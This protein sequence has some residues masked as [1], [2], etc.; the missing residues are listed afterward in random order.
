MVS[1]PVT[2][3]KVDGETVRDI[4][5]LDSKITVHSDHNHEIKML[6]SLQKKLWQT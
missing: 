1:S 5:F 4:I 3:S 6:A 2:S